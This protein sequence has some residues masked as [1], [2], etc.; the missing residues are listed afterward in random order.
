[1]IAFNA[2]RAF[3]VAYSEPCENSPCS[4]VPAFFYAGT[5][6][7][8]RHGWSTVETLEEGQRVLTADYQE[9]EI[10]SLQEDVLEL[11]SCRGLVSDWPVQI[12]EGILNNTQALLVSANQRLVLENPTMRRAREKSLISLRAETLVGYR[13]IAR[14]PLRSDLP[15]VVLGFAQATTL[16]LDGGLRLDVPGMSGELAVP[17]LND[18]QSRSIVHKMR[19][20]LARETFWFK[21]Q[22]SAER[23][24]ASSLPPSLE[25]W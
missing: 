17:P 25:G 7:A 11:S 20:E 16:V 21:A 15:R 18:R 6:L 19:M 14:A 2:R 13:G 24:Q 1:M 3:R 10:I 8:T 12:P 22:K 9:I 23:K 4:V 5:K